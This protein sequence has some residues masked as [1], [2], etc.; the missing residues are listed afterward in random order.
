MYYIRKR[1][2][3]SSSGKRKRSLIDNVNATLFQDSPFFSA[4]K[5][6]LLDVPQFRYKLVHITKYTIVICLALKLI[7]KGM[8]TYSPNWIPNHPQPLIQ[9]KIIVIQKT[10]LFLA[11]WLNS[12]NI[13]S[14]FFKSIIFRWGLTTD[15][16]TVE[17]NFDTL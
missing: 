8:R 1:I 16:Q 10:T 12:R 6:P 4:H 5:H 9:K 14:L 3:S 13:P 17:S 7:K 15:K 2:F 11:Y